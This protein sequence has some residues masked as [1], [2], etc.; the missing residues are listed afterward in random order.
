MWKFS[1]LREKAKDI[2]FLNDS[3]SK[4]SLPSSE[5]TTLRNI[6]RHRNNLQ[7]FSDVNAQEMSRTPLVKRKTL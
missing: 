6:K 3:I 2:H 5:S 4:E 1:E 7:S